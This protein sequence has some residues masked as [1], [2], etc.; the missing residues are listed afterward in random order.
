MRLL[1]APG[2]SDNV[3][4]TEA[5]RTCRR[6][7]KKAAR[8]VDTIGAERQNAGSAGS[9]GGIVRGIGCCEYPYIKIFEA[10]TI[11]EIEVDEIAASGQ[12]IVDY[13]VGWCCRAQSV[14][15]AENNCCRFNHKFLLRIG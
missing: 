5:F 8:G 15:A 14:K 11:M 10:R 13:L 1:Y 9:R 3:A 7:A 4:R 6:G 12:K 2:L